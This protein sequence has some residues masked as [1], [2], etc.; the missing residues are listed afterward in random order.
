MCVGLARGAGLEK[1]DITQPHYN[2]LIDDGGVCVGERR[3]VCPVP[4]ITHTHTHT[5]FSI[6]Q[7]VSVS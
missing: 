6:D 7:S 3:I 2:P 1:D 4:Q 5:L